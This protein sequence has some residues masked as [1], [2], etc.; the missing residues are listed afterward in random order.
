MQLPD[1]RERPVL[2]VEETA[3]ILGCSRS[4]AYD[5]ANAGEIPTLRLGRKIVVPTARLL[6]MLGLDDDTPTAA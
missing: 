1:P 4:R 2:T 6:A 5:S 3:E